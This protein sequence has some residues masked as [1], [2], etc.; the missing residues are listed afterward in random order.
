MKKPATAGFF[1]S[2]IISMQTPRLAYTAPQHLCHVDG[3]KAV[4]L[5]AE[6]TGNINGPLLGQN[7]IKLGFAQRNKHALSTLA[8]AIAAKTN[9]VDL[10]QLH[11]LVMIKTIE[12]LINGQ[13]Q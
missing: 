8:G 9:I 3:V 12:Q 5:I 4:R 7:V 1:M 11:L 10:M 2:S 13:V 6:L